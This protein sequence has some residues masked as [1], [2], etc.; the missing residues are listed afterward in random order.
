MYINETAAF[1]KMGVDGNGFQSDDTDIKDSIFIGPNSGTSYGMDDFEGT[2]SYNLFYDFSD[3]FNSTTE[4][5]T[6]Y[7]SENANEINPV[8]HT[9]TNPTGGLKYPLRVEDES[10]IATQSSTG[11]KLGAE[12]L[13]KY[14][15]DETLHGEAGY[16]TLTEN[17]LWPFPYETVIRTHLIDVSEPPDSE[18]GFCASGQTLTE[19]IWEF[20]GNTIPAEIYG[21]DNSGSVTVGGGSQAITIGGGSQ[22]ITW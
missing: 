10:N 4:H 16:A 3:N 11:G 15:V 8:W 5:G 1:N 17:E 20:M 7:C 19:Y 22:N 9:S 14:G 6:E 13:Y 12:I 2:H 18:R 21:D